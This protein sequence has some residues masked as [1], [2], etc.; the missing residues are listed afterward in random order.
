MLYEM[1][2]VRSDAVWQ[3]GLHHQVVHGKSWKRFQNFS[4]AF[5]IHAKL[6]TAVMVVLV[7]VLPAPV[8]PISSK[9][10]TRC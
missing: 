1:F 2:V 10:E 7:A 5:V 6:L 8:A 9:Y 3:K 4:V